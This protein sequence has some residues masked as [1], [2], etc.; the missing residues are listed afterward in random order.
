M[1]AIG[2]KEELKELIDQEVDHSILKAIRSLL[3]K[4]RIDDTL[5]E[6]LMARALKSNEDIA[7]NRLFTREEIESEDL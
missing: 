7:E 4:A 5:K 6:K 3:V 2:I 1:A